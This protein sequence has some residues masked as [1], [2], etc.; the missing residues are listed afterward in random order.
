M[1][2]A[3]ICEIVEILPD[4]DRF[5]RR[6]RLIG[7]PGGHID[8]PGRGGPVTINAGKRAI[9]AFEQGKTIEEAKE[10]AWTY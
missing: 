7:V 5:T 4:M 9:A 2:H 6:Y 10:A 8:L 3:Q 1:D